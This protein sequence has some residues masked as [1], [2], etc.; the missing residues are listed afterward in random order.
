[1]GKVRV[2]DARRDGIATPVTWERSC[3]SAGIKAQTARSNPGAR[4]CGHTPAEQQQPAQVARTSLDCRLDGIAA[5]RRRGGGHSR[6]SFPLEHKWTPRSPTSPTPGFSPS[7][8]ADQGAR[9]GRRR[10]SVDFERRIVGE[11]SEN[12]TSVSLVGR[13]HHLNTNML[14][15]PVVLPSDLAAPRGAAGRESARSP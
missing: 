12:G 14:F 2:E 6:R 3:S 15:I 4:E 8:W 9:R 7:P 10:W 1:M 13:R 11:T 5:N